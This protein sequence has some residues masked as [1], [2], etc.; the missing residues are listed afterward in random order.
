MIDYSKNLTRIDQITNIHSQDAEDSEEASIVCKS[1]RW[2]GATV[3]EIAEL[4]LITAW[5]FR[6]RPHQPK[7]VILWGSSGTGK[8]LL[9]AEMLMMR[10]AHYRDEWWWS[11][12]LFLGC[13][14]L[15]PTRDSAFT[16][17]TQG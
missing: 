17:A 11:K 7:N 16:H 8:T 3:E 15:R 1:L 4:K 2:F 13:V 12:T 9:L 5:L 10:I 14:I 6:G